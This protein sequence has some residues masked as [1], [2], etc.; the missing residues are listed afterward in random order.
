MNYTDKDNYRLNNNIEMLLIYFILIKWNYLVNFLEQIAFNTRQKREQHIVIVMDK[1][2]REE[3]LSQPLE[4][5]KNQFKI[6]GTFLTGYNGVTNSNKKFFFAKSITDKDG[7]IENTIPAG[8]YEIE[9]LN[10]EIKSIFL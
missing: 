10:N 5:N 7:F 9:K 6:A 3:P 8:V 1:S 4:T 2:T